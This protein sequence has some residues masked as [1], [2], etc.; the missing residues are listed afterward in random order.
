MS[1]PLLLSS[2]AAAAAS[3]WL[4]ADRF[5][6]M[7]PLCTLRNCR[8]NNSGGVVLYGRV[9]GELAVSRAF[10]DAHLKALQASQVP[11]PNSSKADNTS[12]SSSSNSFSFPDATGSSCPGT[13]S[14]CS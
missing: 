3:S 9:M 11:V 2:T 12:N 10:G 6:V 1:Q 8:I 14:S 5:S 7:L 4:P 13:R